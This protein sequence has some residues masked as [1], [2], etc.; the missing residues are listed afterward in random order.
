MGQ[1]PRTPSRG[2][3]ATRRCRW[4]GRG[5]VG[6]SGSLPSLSRLLKKRWAPGSGLLRCLVWLLGALWASGARGSHAGDP[7]A[8]AVFP[9]L[10]LALEFAD[11][12]AVYGAEAEENECGSTSVRWISGS[13]THGSFCLAL[14]G[15]LGL[16]RLCFRAGVPRA[17]AVFPWYAPDPGIRF[18]H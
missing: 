1:S 11:L 10:S 7:R 6:L 18:F 9:R 16:W 2:V 12:G 5:S 14:W 13:G 15:L 17:A 4:E 3:L 8:A